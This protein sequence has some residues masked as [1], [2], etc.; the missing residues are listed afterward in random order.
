MRSILSW[1]YDLND[2]LPAFHVYNILRISNVENSIEDYIFGC[3]TSINEEGDATW[4]DVMGDEIGE[5]FIVTHWCS[6]LE[7]KEEDQ[8]GLMKIEDDVEL[9]D[10]A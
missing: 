2:C 3:L 7:I 6:P 9:E 1:W 8:Q 4:E 10:V 5:D